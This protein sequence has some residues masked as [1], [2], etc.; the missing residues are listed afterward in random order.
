MRRRLERSGALNGHASDDGEDE[1]GVREM[2]LLFVGLRDSVSV[3]SWDDLM[4]ELEKELSPEAYSGLVSAQKMYHVR[5]YLCRS[6]APEDGQSE[7]KPDR[8]F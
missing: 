4:G 2:A 7:M 5:Q 1:V 3:A 6:S 8:G